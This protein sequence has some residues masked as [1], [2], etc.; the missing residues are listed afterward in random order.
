MGFSITSSVFGRVI[1]ICYSISISSIS[2]S[3][4]PQ[5]G[6]ERADIEFS[7]CVKF[8]SKCLLVSKIVSK[9]RH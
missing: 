3:S 6:L 9:L 7:S 4:L 8:E 1:I 5:I 2:I